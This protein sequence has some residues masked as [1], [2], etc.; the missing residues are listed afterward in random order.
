MVQ[1]QAG[2][3]GYHSPATHR[4]TSYLEF[5][6]NLAQGPVQLLRGDTHIGEVDEVTVDILGAHST[7]GVGA[8]LLV[9]E[10][11]RASVQEHRVQHGQHG[12]LHLPSFH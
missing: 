4:A 6:N 5:P 2:V 3:E 11:A 9:V 12:L 8:F 10:L 7:N 1:Q